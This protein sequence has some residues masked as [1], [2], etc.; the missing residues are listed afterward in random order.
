M[1]EVPAWSGAAFER[2]VA[3]VRR[4]L[5]P[6]GC[7]SMM[8]Y[9]CG[10]GGSDG[11]PTLLMIDDENKARALLELLDVTVGVAESAVVPME[12]SEALARIGDAAPGLRD[13]PAYRRLAAAARR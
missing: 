9:G 8:D 7:R 2:A 6:F 10:R 11:E 13:R 3:V 12:L 1:A 5:V 4:F